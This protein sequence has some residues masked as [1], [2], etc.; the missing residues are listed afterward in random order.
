MNRVDPQDLIGVTEIA[1]LA[2]VS[3]AAVCM[4]RTRETDFPKPIVVL[5]CGPIYSQ[6]EV[7]RWLRK[8][9]RS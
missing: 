1:L 9:S 6:K 8:N 2:G 5:K 7:I 3:A 4:W